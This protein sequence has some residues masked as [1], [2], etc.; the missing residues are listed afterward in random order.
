MVRGEE[1]HLQVPPDPRFGHYVR[2]QLLAFARSHG[3]A[4]ADLG[5]F[6]TAVSE[7]LANA[8]EHSHT[9]DAIEV[10]AFVMGRDQVIATVVD[11]GIGFSPRD[12]GVEPALPDALAEHGRGLPIMRRYSDIFSIRSAPGQG[13]TVTLGRYVRPRSRARRSNRLAL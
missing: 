10:S 5:D 3:I 13:T 6:V 7:A 12:A 11:H 1:M 9:T 4:S 2:D 8:I